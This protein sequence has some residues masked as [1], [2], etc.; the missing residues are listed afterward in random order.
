M[1][2][3]KLEQRYIEDQILEYGFDSAMSEHALFD[4]VEDQEFH[5]RL[6]AYVD[7]RDDLAKYVGEV[8]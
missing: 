1:P 8:L 3:R 4:D 7:A 6:K 5:A 2:L